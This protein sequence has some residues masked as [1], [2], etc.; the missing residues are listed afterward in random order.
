MSLLL[1]ALL[2]GF[3]VL[4]TL[5]FCLFEA[6]QKIAALV[7]FAVFILMFHGGGALVAAYNGKFE[8]D[9]LGELGRVKVITTGLRAVSG[10]LLASLIIAVD[11]LLWQIS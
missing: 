7:A 2:C 4:L 10:F 6:T 5:F 11:W 8:H 9:A 1:G 3:V